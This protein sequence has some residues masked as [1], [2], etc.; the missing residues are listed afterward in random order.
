MVRDMGTNHYVDFSRV[1]V[2]GGHH[3]RAGCGV[4]RRAMHGKNH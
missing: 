4:H 1:T 2:V 3:H